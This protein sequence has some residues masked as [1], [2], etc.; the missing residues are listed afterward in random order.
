MSSARGWH[1]LMAPALRV[2][3][4]GVADQPPAEVRRIQTINLIAAGAFFFN[5]T[6]TI[7]YAVLNIR[8]LALVIFP[9]IL[10]SLLY[11]AVIYANARGKSDLA[12]WMVMIVPWA[13]LTIASAVL[14][15]GTG[16]YLFLLFVPML[17]VLIARP[18]DRLLLVLG[19]GLGTLIFVAVGLIFAEGPE[20]LEGSTAQ[21]FMFAGSAAGVAI[22]GSAIVLYYRRLLEFEQERSERLLLNILPSEIAE[23]L[24]RGE[25]P[26]ADRIP[27]VTVLVADIVGFTPMSQ[28]AAASDVVAMLDALFSRFDDLTDELGLDK[29]KTIG[30]AYQAVGGLPG[31]TVDQLASIAEL[32][33]AM[34]A[35]ANEYALPGFGDLQLRIGIA[36]GPVVAGVIGKRKFS[37]EIWGDTINS[38]SRMESEGVPGRI[39]VTEDV[40]QRLRDRYRF[41]PRGV[42]PVK[43]KGD[44]RTYFLEQRIRDQSPSLRM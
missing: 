3:N 9:N 42:I 34:R 5:T 14:G 40:Y 35:E 23:R 30:D 11:L 18:G 28:Q 10:W 32:A 29:L 39:Q 1:R 19:V 22:M 15:S 36:T 6:F 21:Q 24:K 20:F 17:G 33:L 38:A 25:R 4:V 26:I 7:L 13:N 2:A 27:R 37:Y 41:E 16:V 43:G 31:S 12:L 44:M 8:E